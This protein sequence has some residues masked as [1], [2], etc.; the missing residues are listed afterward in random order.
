MTAIE[1]NQ[2]E[3][4]PGRGVPRRHLDGTT[5]VFE[6]VIMLAELPHTIARSR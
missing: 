3:P 5:Q 2:A 4:T 6:R 1:Q